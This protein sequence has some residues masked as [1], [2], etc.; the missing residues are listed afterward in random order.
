MFIKVILVAV[1]IDN[2]VQ[3]IEHATGQVLKGY[4]LNTL[5]GGSINDAYQLQSAQQSYFIKLNQPQRLTMF[6]A[7]A[8][9]LQEMRALN[10]IRIPEVICHGQTT[11]QSY[12]VLEYI[13][14]G[15]LRGQASQKLG[16]QLAQLHRHRQPFF[17]WKMNNTI[18]STPQYNDRE[19]DWPSF[20][21]H[22][23]L[24]QQLKFAAK[25]G[26]GAR[27]QDK[28]QLLLENIH[29]FFE[30]YTPIPALLHGD[31]WGGNAG[32]DPQG[33]PVIF[34]PACYYGDR[35]TDIAMTELFGGFG[36]DFF[37]AYQA[38]YPLDPGY[39][40]RK[41]LYNLY[42]ILNHVNLFGSGYLGQAEGM[43]SQLLAEIK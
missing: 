40:T 43:L 37:A 28:G 39:K 10:C 3:Q 18:G 23:R 26:F 29:L 22:Q 2:I 31:L 4:R 14:L 15:S 9:G 32:A 1:N 7:E 5:G 27:L 8:L 30:T 41:T 6:E 16:T 36:A 34:D 42:H 17:G 33:N 13:E 12:L 20:W 11:K 21:Q 35:E 19:H 38:E 25:N 24:G